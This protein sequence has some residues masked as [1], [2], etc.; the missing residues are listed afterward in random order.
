ML[1]ARDLALLAAVAAAALYIRL[2]GLWWDG[3]ASLHADERHMLLV[4]GDLLHR[5]DESGLSPWSLWFDADQSPLNPHR[6]GI[7]YVY[8]EA[9]LILVLLL[10]QTLDMTTWTE[11][12]YLGRTVT[13]VLDASITLAVFAMVF[14]TT[15]RRRPAFLGA[16]FY[17]LSPLALQN[18]VFFTTDVWLGF[19]SAYCA[20]C[21][22]YARQTAEPGRFLR[23]M[24]LAGLFA[25]LALAS[26]ITGVLLLLPIGA[27]LVP[28]RHARPPSVIALAVIC[29]VVSALVTFRVLNPY[30]FSGPQ[31]WSLALNPAV[32]DSFAELSRWS[33]NADFPPNWYWQ[34]HYGVWPFLRD[35]AVFG[36]GPPLLL[37]LG[38][39]LALLVRRVRQ[40]EVLILM[41]LGLAPV[42]FCLLMDTPALRY[43]LPALP[44]WA[45]LAGIA[46]SG[47]GPVLQVACLCLAAWWGSGMVRLHMLPHPRIIASAFLEALP[48]GTVVANETVWD[49]TLPVRPFGRH[50]TADAADLILLDLD[51]TAADG[52][53]KARDL[54]RVAARA[55]IIAVSSGRIRQS[56]PYLDRFAMVRAWYDGLESGAFCYRLIQRIDHGY[57]LPGW[58]LDDAWAQQQWRVFDHP[59]VSLYE[60]QSCFSEARVEQHLLDAS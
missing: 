2:L 43:L 52:P 27:A 56:M 35:L 17:A 38:S 16:A 53:E 37:A 42:L 7:V 28:G 50:V 49:E 13:C 47:R 20:V 55:D 51:L 11:L 33:A 6:D 41:A 9:P 15:G 21:L 32:A 31:P 8:G 5:L 26:K 24:C 54:A 1:R 39:G 30:A 3:G 48:D 25:G 18:A 57:P 29:G 23:R 4:L 19:S 46:L 59:I 45:A 22:I 40:G 34:A 60:R 58:R 36:F 14:L 12:Q 10:A 44:A